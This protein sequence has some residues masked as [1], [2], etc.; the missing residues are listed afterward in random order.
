MLGF[1]KTLHKTTTS[2]DVLKMELINYQWPTIE[3]VRF[4]GQ[5]Y[6][7]GILR[8]GHTNRGQ[9]LGA[10]P[11][12][13]AAA[14]SV[15]SWTR[16]SSSGRSAFTFRRIDRGDVGD[17]AGTGVVN[18]HP[19]DVI[20]A[21]GAERMRFGRWVDY[22]AKIEAMQDYNRNFAKDVPNLNLQLTGQLHPW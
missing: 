17:F 13:G 9:L 5:I 14:G 3:R 4:E 2:L 12:V 1:Q 19:S 20:V 6:L 11:G 21:V 16:Y 8:Q 15:I 7:H 18:P 10:Y 22:G